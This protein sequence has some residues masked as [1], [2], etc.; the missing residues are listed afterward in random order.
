VNVRAGPRVSTLDAAPNVD[1]EATVQQQLE[2][3]GEPA[4][5]RDVAA[6]AKDVLAAELDAVRARVR[7]E[8]R[9]A[10]SR[11]LVARVNAEAAIAAASL[12]DDLL[13]MSEARVIA[14]DLSPLAVPLARADLASARQ[15]ATV[16]IG[17]ARARALALAELAGMTRVPSHFQ[18][19]QPAL[20]GVRDID[21]LIARALGES[22]AL[23]PLVATRAHAAARL[24][25][26]ERS[27]SW[28]ATSRPSLG[29]SYAAERAPQGALAGEHIV[30]GTLQF[31]VPSWQ[32]NQGDVQ[33]AR[34]ELAVL[35]AALGNERRALALRMRASADALDDA[36]QVVRLMDAELPAL[37]GAL[38]QIRRAFQLG[39]LDALA[40]AGARDKLVAATRGALAARV[41]HVEALAALER[42]LGRE[43]R[44][45]EMQLDEFAAPT[46]ER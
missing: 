19:A 36:V 21:A 18:G 2:I 39:E 17:E 46:E 43:L 9:A 8:V 11:A 13:R 32:S 20:G 37:D 26:L 16:A 22:A 41:Q 7:T 1:V 23:A 42:D 6:R 14:G 44:L 33:R 27:S 34:T 4:L 5:R 28:L 30:L 31:E 15:S 10:F 35:D 29:A 24:A 38:Q 12:S 3:A 45:D 40:V 25:F